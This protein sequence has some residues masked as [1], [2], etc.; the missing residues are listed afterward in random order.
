MTLDNRVLLVDKPAGVT[1]F[2]AVRRLRKS[3]A[4]DKAGHCGSLDPFAT[5]LLVVCTGVAT[6]VAELFVDQAKEYIGRVC[7]GRATDTYDIDGR[8]TAEGPVPPLDAAM[9][10]RALA[11]FIGDIEQVPPMVSALKVDGRRLYDLARRGVEIERPP[12]RVRVY[13]I[14]LLAHGDDWADLRV[15]CGRGCY[16]R[17]IAFDLGTALGVP[18]H[19]GVLRRTAIGALHVDDAL[20]PDAFAGLGLPH[21]AVRDVADALEFLPALRVR[22][23]AEVAVRNGAQPLPHVLQP[24]PRDRGRH[25]LLSE[26]GRRLIAIGVAG[27]GA[28]AGPA[29]V[30][31]ET[32]FASPL[33]ASRAA[34]SVPAALPEAAT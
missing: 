32:V 27:E 33:A 26:D 7:F 6:R 30:R 20:A 8:T 19:L 25:R 12:R 2:A 23:A 10:Q 34:E 16:V 15:R 4:V 28:G 31:L 21:A 1:S 13:G 22:A 9:L 11:A 3:A 5:G 14:E 17:S 18:A 24:Q 29:P